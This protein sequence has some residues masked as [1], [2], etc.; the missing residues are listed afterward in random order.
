[1]TT[2]PASAVNAVMLAVLVLCQPCGLHAAASRSQVNSIW[3]NIRAQQRRMADVEGQVNASLGK[4]LAASFG[5]PSP[6]QDLNSAVNAHVT[7]L[8]GCLR[9]IDQQVTL[10]L[11]ADSGAG[12]PTVAL[13][14]PFTGPL[15][16]VRSRKRQIADVI[17]KLE[18]R[19]H[20]QAQAIAKLKK[21]L[22]KDMQNASVDLAAN[23]VP[24]WHE[25]LLGG[26]CSVVGV[27]VFPPAAVAAGGFFLARTGA[28]VNYQSAE[29]ARQ[30]KTYTDVLNLL[31]QQ[32]KLDESELHRLKST[33]LAEIK[34]IERDFEL[35][36]E[37][38]RKL[39]KSAADY[40]RRWR[41]A[42]PGARKQQIEKELAAVDTQTRRTH[43][44]MSYTTGGVSVV[45]NPSD[46][47]GDVRNGVET[48]Q[49]G[50]SRVLAGADPITYFADIHALG[51]DLRD[52]YDAAR[53][54]YTAANKAYWAASAAYW[55]SYQS[56]WKAYVRSR[57][58]VSASET[59]AERRR[60]RLAALWD[61]FAASC[62]ALEGPVKAAAKARAAAHKTMR[63]R[64]I[65][66][67]EVRSAMDVCCAT[68][69]STA[70]SV[71]RGFWHTVRAWE[72]DTVG[73]AEWDLRAALALAPSVASI[74]S[75]QKQAAELD[76]TLA[77]AF[78]GHSDPAPLQ[79]SLL[80][81]A[82]DV[83]DAD[84]ALR[85]T[86]PV[87]RQA[88]RKVATSRK[89]ALSD[90]QQQLGS[91]G[92]LVAWDGYRLGTGQLWP[93]SQGSAY[94]PPD[95]GQ[96]DKRLEQLSERLGKQF[97][98]PEHL[99]VQERAL[100]VLA[101][102][103]LGGMGSQFEEAARRLTEIIDFIEFY[104]GRR[105][106]ALYRLNL[107]CQEQAGCTIGVCSQRGAR[108]LLMHEFGTPAWQAVS[109]LAGAVAP[110]SD[111]RRA[112]GVHHTH[113]WSDMLPRDR[114]DIAARAVHAL[115]RDDF[116][117]FIRIS[118]SGGVM[119]VKAELVK[120]AQTKHA[121]L[122]QVIAEF[123]KLAAPL[124]PPVAPALKRHAEAVRPVNA[125]YEK[126]PA[127]WRAHIQRDHAHFTRL[128]SSLQA[129]L[130]GK[131]SAVAPLAASGGGA[132]FAS[133]SQLLDDY[134]A[135]KKR[136]DRMNAEADARRRAAE[137]EQARKLR[138]TEARSQ[139]AEQHRDAVRALY[140]E[141]RQ[142]YEDQDEVALIDL[143]DG[144]WSA[145]GGTTRDDLEETLANSFAAFDTITCGISG[146]QIK[147]A[148]ANVYEASYVITI[149]GEILENDI[150]HEERSSVLERLRVDA[151]GR[152]RITK[153]ITGRYWRDAE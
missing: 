94:T 7:T 119:L 146:L 18:T 6:W 21:H 56:L 38:Y 30:A 152:V 10:L 84:R 143:I 63:C 3:G 59:D 83:R 52:R 28:E 71:A 97:G 78:G 42:V 73:A 107:L 68:L 55:Q 126:M 53:E 138:E 57:R 96:R 91:C 100:Q 117:H 110:A 106:V 35:H 29:F 133:L 129:Y 24:G 92:F 40:A 31:G 46:Y 147:D 20:A 140:G 116:K 134:A 88:W 101:K 89:E 4:A 130:D 153:T 17:A 75:W 26:L 90:L 22:R 34:A 80:A 104:R 109:G 66:L 1:M 137:Q 9:N 44:R 19:V 69:S 23:L 2:K 58:A 64:A 123:E 70:S 142:A 120:G 86:L 39:S 132:A 61:S 79:Q 125:A 113:Q 149:V 60:A 54:P 118:A 122:Q 108:R 41:Q 124:R 43:V 36:E 8:D 27:L 65:V 14:G 151:K 150:R 51:R 5:D 67:S 102:A 45:I 62:R 47:E 48:L 15:R 145:E 50:L 74:E 136:V 144:E 49:S 139:L 37:K 32:K 85:K 115:T 72:T 13:S 127:A 111:R 93:S 76:A 87:C 82:R 98:E 103:N 114:V 95:A 105:D 33:A 128:A 121:A 16:R 141:F 131:M 12:L 11:Q 25:L 81:A 99:H 112:R 148:G 77:R 135:M